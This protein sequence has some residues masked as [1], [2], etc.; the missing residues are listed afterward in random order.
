MP[1]G[2]PVCANVTSG[3]RPWLVGPNPLAPPNAGAEKRACRWG[4]E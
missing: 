3:Q 2:G 1:C 4:G